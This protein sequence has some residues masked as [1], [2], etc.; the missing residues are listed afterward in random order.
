[1]QFFYD[2]PQL[3]RLRNLYDIVTICSYAYY[4]P[5]MG[6]HRTRLECSVDL[7]GLGV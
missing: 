1:M 6:I 2:F 7:E 4:E 3:I 5:G